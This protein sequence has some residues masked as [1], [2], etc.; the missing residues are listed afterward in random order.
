MIVIDLSLKKG[1]IVICLLTCNQL[2]V[3][4]VIFFCYI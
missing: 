4:R 3:V 1:L 2:V